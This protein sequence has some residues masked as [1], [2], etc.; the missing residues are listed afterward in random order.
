MDKNFKKGDWVVF[1]EFN[2]FPVQLEEGAVYGYLSLFLSGDCF[3]RMSEEEIKTFKLQGDYYV[4]D[5]RDVFESSCARYSWCHISKVKKAT[6]KDFNKLIKELRVRK[7]KTD[8]ELN[9]I[10]RVRKSI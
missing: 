2:E 5:P 1:P 9:R 3:F 4:M 6:K 8:T 10:I 7:N